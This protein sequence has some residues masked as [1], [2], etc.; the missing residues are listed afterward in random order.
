MQTA[1]KPASLYTYQFTPTLSSTEP[2]EW[3]TKLAIEY[4]VYLNDGSFARPTW[5]TG[6]DQ[7]TKKAT[8]Q[9][10]D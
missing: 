3:T 6:Y 4:D 1:P 5:I 2:A 8:I 9:S 10:D 7:A